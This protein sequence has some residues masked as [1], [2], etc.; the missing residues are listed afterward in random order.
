MTAMLRKTIY[1][2]LMLVLSAAI[3]LAL[4]TTP[5]FAE[6]DAAG[7][8]NGDTLEAG[9]VI[10]KVPEAG[11]A[12]G[13]ELL[14]KY[15]D[16]RV[17]S[18]L[19]VPSLQGE[20]RRLAR[21]PRRSRLNSIEKY[22]YDEILAKMEEI[23]SG[24]AASAEFSI[25][26]SEQLADYM[27]DEGPYRVIT[28]ES[29]G[30]SD[31]VCIRYVSYSDYG[32]YEEMDFSEE[33]AARLFDTGKVVDA[34]LTDNPYPSYWFDKVSG[35]YYGLN[36]HI[37]TGASSSDLYFPEDPRFDIGFTVA[38][39]YR[40]PNAGVDAE[41]TI[42]RGKA[43]A[44]ASA[45]ATVESIVR[46][47]SSRSD[48]EKLN[49]YKDVIC[50][51]TSYNDDAAYD[52]FMPYGDPWQLIW[53]FDGDSST[54]V[55]CEGYSKAFQ[56]LCDKSSFGN[57]YIECRTVT[58][59]LGS[60]IGA[61]DHMW[62]ILH[63]DDGKN[64]L[65]DITN[66]DVDDPADP[67]YPS[68]GVYPDDLFLKGYIRMP[69]SGIYA[70]GYDTTYEY[71]SDTLALY[72]EAELAISSADYGAAG[73]AKQV[74]GIGF[75]PVS[76]SIRLSDGVDGHYENGVFIYEMPFAEGDRLDVSYYGSDA[77]SVYVFEKNSKGFGEFRADGSVPEGAPA[78]ISDL[79]IL[80]QSNS[81]G[82]AWTAGN[83]YQLELSYL[84]CAC[85]V[86]VTI[87]C[88]H[89][90]RRFIARTDPSCIAGGV[91][92]H[93]ECL[94]CGSLLVKSGGRYSETT[95]D[96]LVIPA[97][98]QHKWGEAIYKWN[99][100]YTEVTATHSCTVCG[101]TVTATAKR[102]FA[103]EIK[104][105]TAK[106]KGEIRYV[107]EAFAVDGFKVQTV[108]VETDVKTG[109]PSGSV[110]P[111]G[112]AGAADGSQQKDTANTSDQSGNS[113]NADPSSAADPS[114]SVSTGKTVKKNGST[115][116]VT[117]VKSRTVALTKAKNTKNV[118]VPATVKLADGKTY[119][120]TAIYARA[121]TGKSIRKV[122]VGKNVKRIKAK[123]FYGSK[124]TTV[125]VR[126]KLLK[127]SCVKGSLKGSK[128]KTIR[129]KVSTGKSTNRKYLTK[130]KKYFTKANAGR[131]VSV[132]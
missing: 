68:D 54:N 37:I 103:E 118:T 83:S 124:A 36:Y 66:C 88:G 92:A 34:L 18:A 104:A 41:F 33:A 85:S 109:E 94:I 19:G 50:A 31:P 130:Y 10:K 74:T 122:T 84:G 14:G 70:F 120:V 8:I 38:E 25:D 100:D 87:V 59:L 123:A 117:S 90:D 73:G 52:P 67:A 96:A 69:A 110:A 76:E 26:L 105:A 40:D 60:G 126:T 113:G 61:G 91:E 55:V 125:T 20:K 81:G 62:N 23:A 48:I 28:S 3:G 22:L 42:D 95:A 9:S 132:K 97:N 21:T 30:I 46:D 17:S 47:N 82:P 27:E 4:V 106:E 80:Q 78:L 12:D 72:S 63:M 44:A 101:T 13:D 51:L 116:K 6:S 24:N 7:E 43:G 11:S 77:P 58:G 79:D 45:A 56:Y 65:A 111:S 131:K 75:R 128:V 39:E 64:Y 129:V 98:G 121:F 16:S 108:I 114:A 99:A 5:V 127:K 119:K 35:Y 49:A 112:A 93:Y 86:P 15:F 1:S 53:V 2:L 71:D 102:A 115:Y 57:R 32:Y 29:L 107:S 89:S